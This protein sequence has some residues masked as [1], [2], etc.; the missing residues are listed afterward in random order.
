MNTRHRIIAQMALAGCL[1]L[2]ACSQDNSNTPGTPAEPARVE[3]LTIEGLNDQTWVYVSLEQG[4]VVGSS[5]LGDEEQDATWKARTDWDFALCGELIRTNSGTSGT[6]NGGIQ[7]V[8]NKS[9]NALDEA[10][11]DG[12]TVDTDDRIIRH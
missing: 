10:P 6:G 9:F 2:G 4:K 7:S 8:T 11:T 5:P 3:S 12:Y 1:W